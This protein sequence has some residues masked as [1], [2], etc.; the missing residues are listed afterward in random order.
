MSERLRS[1]WSRHP[2]LREVMIWAIPALLVGAVLRGL[3]LS[4]LP[5]AYWGSDSRSYYSF[6][7]KLLSDGYISLDEKR[8]FLYPIFMVP[9]SLLPGAPLRWLAWLQHGFGLLTL[10]PLA[11][12]VRKSFVHWRWWI[13][14]V[15]VLYAGLPV[16]LWY[17]HELLGETIMFAGVVWAFAGW[18]A[19]VSEE[20]RA[21]AEQLFWWFFVPFALVILTKPSARF[22]WPGLLL[23]LLAVQAWRRLGRKQW[24]AL[25]LL[26]VVTLFV[27]SKKQGAW[28][29]YVATF[30]L[31]NFDSPLHHE[32]KA[33]VR[34]MIAPLR[35]NIDA[36]YLLDGGP[37]A[38]L[39]APGAQ[40]EL[41]LFKALGSDEKK[42]A[43]IYMDLAKEA[44]LS[45]P[46]LFLYL[47]AQRVIASANISEFK[48]DRFTGDFYVE[49][50]ERTHAEAITKKN[51]PVRMLFALPK[52]KP[53][54]AYPE[55]SRM[56]SP[57]PESWMARTV[58]AWV[59]GYEAASDLV[60]M[61]QDGPEETRSI[62]L[63]RPTL[64]GLWLCLG[65]GLS[66]L[67]RYHMTLGVWMMMALSYLFG[68][69]LFAGI[70][71]RYFGAAW[72]VLI[73]LL[74]VPADVL[75]RM[76]A[77]RVRRRAQ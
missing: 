58:Q 57:A 76:I 66:L 45:N 46:G 16:I 12:V 61:P 64:L 67:P 54:P 74:A 31:T 33:E 23:G 59:R 62:R 25:G 19:W 41:P 56:L 40:D 2:I 29:L 73:P 52:D 32:Y 15:T 72:P 68:V 51:S 77:S 20:R 26:L 10:L 30:P 55:F 70:N 34:D 21:R 50:F 22:F 28:L 14:P 48:E 47:G 60:R 36:Y 37:F 8:R 13:V 4:Y 3:M 39:E 69:F 5:Y 1:F 38:F 7:H 65:I 71:P 24:V 11:Y 44:I 17:E 27:G 43:R 75:V 49:R 35:Q 42:K 53:V 9:V 18:C 6:A 63:A